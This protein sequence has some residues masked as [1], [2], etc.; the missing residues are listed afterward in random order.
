MKNTAQL[1]SMSII[2]VIKI[3]QTKYFKCLINDMHSEH[4]LKYNHIFNRNYKRRRKMIIKI[5][6]I[7]IN[8]N[9][10]NNINLNFNNK[11]KWSMIYNINHS[12]QF[13][14]IQKLMKE[15]KDK[16]KLLIYLVLNLSFLNRSNHLNPSRAHN[17]DGVIFKIS[18]YIK[19]RCNFKINL[20]N[21]WKRDKIIMKFCEIKK[22]I[23]LSKKG[24]SLMNIIF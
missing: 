8:N 3:K 5:Y 24:T 2:P 19:I 15:S 6:L 13:L 20:N 1:K 18:R 7:K 9:N 4:Y 17:K 10:N 14:K 21:K 23:R 16:I 22:S 11:D 12:R